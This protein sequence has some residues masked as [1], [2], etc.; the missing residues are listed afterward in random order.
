MFSMHQGWSDG[1][2]VKST[3]CSCRELGSVPTT[4]GWLT[5]ILNSSFKT[6]DTSSDL[7]G[8]L[9]VHDAHTLRHVWTCAHTCACTHAHTHIF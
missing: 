2:I 4:T 6:S 3:G 7:C 9:H 1:S 8:F 5:T